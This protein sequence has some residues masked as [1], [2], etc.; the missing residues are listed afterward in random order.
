MLVGK[1]K[2]SISAEIGYLIGVVEY[3]HHTVTFTVDGFQRMECHCGFET[4]AVDPYNL[5]WCT[6]A[7]DGCGWDHATAHA[8]AMSSVV[9]YPD[10]N[11][12]SVEE[13]LQRRRDRIW[14]QDREMA[15]AIA[16]TLVVGDA[17]DERHQ[18]E[19]E[20]TVDRIHNSLHQERIRQ[21][22]ERVEAEAKE[23]GMA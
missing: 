14:K 9:I 7:V 12:S 23:G 22:W 3:K 10:D 1:V 5:R 18:R 13:A 19:Y 16:D 4:H 8:M 2:L 11:S 6:A 15:R 21:E 17:T 20:M